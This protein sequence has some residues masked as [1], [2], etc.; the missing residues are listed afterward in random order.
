MFTHDMVE[1]TQEVITIK[2]IDPE[3][4]ELLINFAYSGKVVINTSNVQSLLVGASFLQVDKVRDACCDFMKKRLHTK[5]VLGVQSLA[6]ALGCTTLVEATNR[7]IRAYFIELARTEEYLNLSFEDI[8][9]F[10]S[11][12]LCDFN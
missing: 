8:K 1:S 10:V 4:L 12:V 5:N 9:D 6:N 11:K 7:F 2:E 3:A